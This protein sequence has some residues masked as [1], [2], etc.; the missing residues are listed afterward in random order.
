MDQCLIFCRTNFDCDN[1]EAFLNACG[2]GGVFEGNARAD[3]NTPLLVRGARRVAFDG[4]TATKPP[5]VQRGRRS[6]S[7]LHGRRRARHRRSGVYRTSS[8]RQLPEKSE[9]YIAP[10]QGASLI[11]TGVM[12]L[13]VSVVS[14]A[15]EKVWYCQKKGY[16]PWF[17]PS[18]DDR[19]AHSAWIDEAELLRG[20]EKHG[21][22]PRWAR[23]GAD[24]FD[25]GCDRH[26]LLGPG[27]RGGRGHRRGTN[28]EVPRPRG[29]AH[30]DWAA[31]LGSSGRDRRSSARGRKFAGGAARIVAAADGW[32][33]LSSREDDADSFPPGSSR[34]FAPR[35]REGSRAG[36]GHDR[37]GA[38]R[39][40]V[41]APRRPRTVD[42][43]GGRTR[44]ERPLVGSP[45]C[46]ATRRPLPDRCTWTPRPSSSPSVTR[47]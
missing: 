6:V 12:G 28:V 34:G 26:A 43:H 46:G 45:S 16:K 30:W 25:G 27:C 3:R 21:W 37:S 40:P 39:R 29:F 1:L 11:Q 44:A 19:T 38:R 8:T 47:A 22:A 32:L 7:H 35:P 24:G 31:L 23:S 2:G 41:S 20:V 5:R 33:G 14:S 15:P 13:A 36:L 42:G 18:R 9:D 10:R 17:K 4:R